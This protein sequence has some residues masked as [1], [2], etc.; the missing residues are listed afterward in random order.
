MKLRVRLLQIGHDTNEAA[1]EIAAD[2]MYY[3][4]PSMHWIVVGMICILACNVLNTVVGLAGSVFERIQ[5]IWSASE[6]SVYP[7]SNK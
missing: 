3:C 2:W 6:L 1:Y 5:L 4:W 7:L